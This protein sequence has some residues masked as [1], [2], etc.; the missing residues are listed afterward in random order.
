ML[1]TYGL[2]HP[3]HVTPGSSVILD[4]MKSTVDEI[5][6]RFDQDV[7]RFSNLESGQTATMD[8]ALVLDMIQQ[9]VPLA[10]PAAR[11][12]LDIG[13][14][15]GNFTLKILSAFPGTVRE[16]DCTLIDLS[17]P[18]LDR[19]VSRIG[20]A[21]A[22]RITA[23][24][25]D[26]RELD[27]G[28]EKFDIAVAGAVL[29]HLREESEWAAVFARLHACLKPGGSLWIW[30]F[31]SHDI[32]AIQDL[33]RARWRQYLTTLKGA[34]Y[35]DQVVAYTDREDSPRSLLFQC[36]LLR[37]SGFR[38]VEV[39]HKITCFAAFCATK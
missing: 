36:D 15:A 33:M 23:L 7:D 39:L 29:H 30:D 32:P 22:G 19:A 26:V 3:L 27:L 8:A 21:G 12:I 17:R 24:Q 31:I 37:Q 4:L 1:P 25:G 10:A 11:S 16:M 34:E 6:R 2:D 28:R 20:Q 18:M 13:C 35:R 14:G 5:R 9:A 38:A